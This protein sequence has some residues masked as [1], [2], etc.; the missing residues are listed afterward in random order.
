MRRGDGLA[1]DVLFTRY[2]AWLR[3]WAGGRLPAWA[4]SFVDTGDLVQDVLLSTF[5]RLS[6]FEPR[7]NGALR[8]YLRLAVE[9]RIRDEI[10]RAGRRPA[11]ACLDDAPGREPSPLERVIDDETWTRYRLA[12]KRLPP[13]ERRLIVG[14][15]E[16][17]YSFKQLAFIDGR[18]SPDAARMATR[19]AL[20]RLSIEMDGAQEE[21]GGR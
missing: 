11:I 14:R 15:A 1:L 6:R 4:R 10:R 16:L 18:V 2:L 8:A 20:V 12:L 7:R 13:R 17:G 19:R 9:N 21:R 5:S 3:R